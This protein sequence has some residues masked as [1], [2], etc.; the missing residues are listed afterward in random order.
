MNSVFVA[1]FFFLP[2]TQ[3]DMQESALQNDSKFVNGGGF[4]HVE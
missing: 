1:A 3:F 2:D 4:N